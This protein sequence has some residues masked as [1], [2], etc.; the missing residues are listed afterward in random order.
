MKKKNHI[1]FVARGYNNFL[2]YIERNG[3]DIK[4]YVYIHDIEDTEGFHISMV[5]EH[6]NA[7][8][9]HDYEIIMKYFKERKKNVIKVKYE[10][11]I[12]KK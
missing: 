3:L 10:Q 5:I 8:R 11:L 12:A 6:E 9:L 1:A 4:D 7:V 2:S